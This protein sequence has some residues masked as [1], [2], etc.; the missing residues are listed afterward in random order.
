MNRRQFFITLGVPALALP[1]VKLLRLPREKEKFESLSDFVKAVYEAQT[2]GII[3]S[4]LKFR[5]LPT[6]L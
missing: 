5:A 4:R 2:K 6:K 1:L 3:D